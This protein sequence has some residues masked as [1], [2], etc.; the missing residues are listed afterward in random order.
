MKPNL[1]FY[2]QTKKIHGLELI[3]ECDLIKKAVHKYKI[4]DKAD[5]QL[6]I[7][8]AEKL[9]KNNWIRYIIFANLNLAIS[10]L[11]MEEQIKRRGGSQSSIPFDNKS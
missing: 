8:I 9:N 6:L 3:R 2:K 10:E 11:E 1:D 5:E 7:D 4:V